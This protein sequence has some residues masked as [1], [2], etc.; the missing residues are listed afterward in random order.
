MT[1]FKAVKPICYDFSWDKNTPKVKKALTS[2]I[3]E[4]WVYYGT[5]KLRIP[6]K[7]KRRDSK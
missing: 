2:L 5:M 1:K 6:I 4:G 3:D 7:R